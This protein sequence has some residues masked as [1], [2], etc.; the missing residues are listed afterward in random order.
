MTFLKADMWIVPGTSSPPPVPR[1]LLMLLQSSTRLFMPMHSCFE[2]FGFDFLPRSNGEVVVLE[3][4]S[5]FDPFAPSL[6]APLPRKPTPRAPA[7]LHTHRHLSPPCGA[8]LRGFGQVN[9]GPALEGVA[10]PHLCEPLVDDVLQV[11]CH[12]KPCLPPSVPT[13][14]HVPIHSPRTHSCGRVF[15]YPRLPPPPRWPWR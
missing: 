15:L 9:G 13:S 2:V 14:T 10:M 11:G 8:L 6:P 12:R 4:R 3:V 7:L 5:L 1:M